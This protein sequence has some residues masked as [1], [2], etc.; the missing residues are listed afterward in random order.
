MLL[1]FMYRF[2]LPFKS[3]QYP[4]F[5]H[6]FADI[7]VHIPRAFLAKVETRPTLGSGYNLPSRSSKI[8]YNQSRR[9]SATTG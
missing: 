6:P 5:H 7:A 9:E 4:H 2:I 8:A 3:Q 1:T